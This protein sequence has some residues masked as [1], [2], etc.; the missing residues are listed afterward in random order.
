M[1]ILLFNPNAGSVENLGLTAD[2]LLAKLQERGVYATIPP[3]EINEDVVR[4]ALGS[5]ARIIAAGGDGTIHNLLKTAAGC[6]FPNMG[7]IPLGTAN[8]LAVALSIPNDIDTAI[9]I[10]AAGHT[11]RIDLGRVNGTVFTQAAGAGLHARIFH[12][13]GE[14]K[15]KKPLDATAAAA[16]ALAGFQPRLMRVVLDGQPYIGELTQVTAANT[17]AY[18]RSFVIAPDARIDDGLL[19]VVLV[20]SLTK[21]EILAYAQAAMQGRLSE[22]KKTYVTRAQ[23]V[24]VYSVEAEAVE[25]HADAQP[26]G[27]TPA[28]IEVIPHCIEVTAPEVR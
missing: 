11:R 23:K 25:I 7:I 26:V 9:D 5:G 10:I 19:D 14:R 4:D 15:E 27:H 21:V 8:H 6:G 3:G 13:Y 17:P 16:R 18:G 12:D 24:E 1:D 20:H 22:M 2:Q 28:V